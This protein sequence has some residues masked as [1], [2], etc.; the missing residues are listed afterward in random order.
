MEITA[1]TQNYCR[2]SSFL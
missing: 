2:Y 1:T